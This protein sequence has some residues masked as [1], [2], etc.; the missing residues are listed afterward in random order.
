MESHKVSLGLIDSPNWP[1]IKT[2]SYCM[3]LERISKLKIEVPSTKD[4]GVSYVRF[5]RKEGIK[6]SQFSYGRQILP[7]F[8]VDLRTAR[9]IDGTVLSEVYNFERLGYP[10]AIHLRI[11]IPW[12]SLLSRSKEQKEYQI[13][14]KIR[15]YEKNNLPIIKETL[16]EIMARIAKEITPNYRT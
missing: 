16:E 15:S 13:H 10:I 6:P 8:L 5:N 7:D 3:S 4:L 1:S 9:D 11:D 2:K 12:L 14:A